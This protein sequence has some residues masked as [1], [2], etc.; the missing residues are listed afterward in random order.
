M[1][2]HDHHFIRKNTQQVGVKSQN[3]MYTFESEIDPWI[4]RNWNNF[5][6]KGSNFIEFSV[7][8][9]CYTYNKN[10]W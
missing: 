8:I 7:H 5:K 9:I 2:S 10:K 1:S 6:N 3:G 4:L